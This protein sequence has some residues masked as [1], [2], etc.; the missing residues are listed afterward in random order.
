M[1]TLFNLIK[2]A[3]GIAC[4]SRLVRSGTLFFAIKGRV[5]DGNSYAWEAERR[6]AIA[7]VTDQQPP[8]VSIPVIVTPNARKAMAEAAAL[9]Y[10]YPSQDLSVI[11]VTGTNGKTTVT[12]MLDHIFRQSG[13]RTGLIGTIKVNTGTQSFPSHLTTPDAINLQSYLA[14]MRANGVSHVPMEVSAQGVEMHRVDNLHFSCGLLTNISP[15][16]LDFH[17][18]FESYLAAKQQFLTLLDNNTPLIVNI[19]DRHCHIIAQKYSGRLITAAINTDADICATELKVNAYGSS[20]KLKTNKLLTATDQLLPPS[21]ATIHV[22][23]PGLHNI[24]N[25]LLAAAA[26]IVQGVPVNSIAAALNS[27]QGAERR[28]TVFH[29]NNRT[30]IDDTALNPG[31]IEAVLDSLPAF[32]CRRILVVN[33]IR[34]NRGTAINQANALAIAKWQKK[35]G[36]P[37]II[38]SSIGHSPP[39]DTVNSDEKAAFL[40]TLDRLHVGYTYFPYLESAL[41][42]VLAESQPN[43]LIALLGAQGMDEGRNIL[44]SLAVTAIGHS[45]MTTNEFDAQPL[46]GA[47]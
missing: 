10:Q 18:S 42:A 12:Y 31:S 5:A 19:S 39:S 41:E 26:A 45:R 44:N 33:A 13:L 30:V 6:G 43:D 1:E 27:F 9:F 7:I 32:R 28:M 34:G 8:S 24:E 4:D 35:L 40:G 3:T 23:I 16:H 22:P 20:F 14:Q 47:F 17:G 29:L 46:A 11:G 25:A 15:D 2:R 38:T 36:F 37:L 21:T